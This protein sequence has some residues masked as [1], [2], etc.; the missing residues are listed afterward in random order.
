MNLDLHSYTCEKSLDVSGAY[1]W[2]MVMASGLISLTSFGQKKTAIFCYLYK[3]VSGKPWNWW[4][5][6]LQVGFCGELSMY[7][8][9]LKWDF[10]HQIPLCVW[11]VTLLYWLNLT[12][13]K[14]TGGCHVSFIPTEVFCVQHQE[15]VTVRVCNSHVVFTPDDVGMQSAVNVLSMKT[16]Q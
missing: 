9:W 15:F 12:A 14:F 1:Y 6:Y 2:V 3:H 8:Y 10:G 4:V 5:P 7:M 13:V 11:Q 16:Q